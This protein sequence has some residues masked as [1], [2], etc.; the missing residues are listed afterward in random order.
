MP[1]EK[2]ETKIEQKI[3]EIPKD[4]NA[5]KVEV[6]NNTKNEQVIIEQEELTPA[7]PPF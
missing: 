4:N 3:T 2:V 1:E 5:E 6:K 7:K